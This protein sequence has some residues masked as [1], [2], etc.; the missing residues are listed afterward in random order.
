MGVLGRNETE[1]RLTERVA[2]RF[3]GTCIA[4]RD[5]VKLSMASRISVSQDEP[6]DGTGKR[7]AIDDPGETRLLCFDRTRWWKIPTCFF[8][9]ISI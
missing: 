1:G 7:K 3:V 6:G 2:N 5:I 4:R 9:F 8:L